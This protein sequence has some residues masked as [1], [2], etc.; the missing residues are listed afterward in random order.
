MSSDT[1]N[2]RV[3]GP[4]RPTETGPARARDIPPSRARKPRKPTAEERLEAAPAWVQVILRTLASEYGVTPWDL[5]E[6]NGTR[7]AGFPLAARRA[8]EAAVRSVY[9]YGGRRLLSHAEIGAIFGVTRQAITMMIAAPEG[10]SVK[11]R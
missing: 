7:G 10:E 1:T 3:G 8:R 5:L 11:W 2:R 4:S 6:A 9:Q